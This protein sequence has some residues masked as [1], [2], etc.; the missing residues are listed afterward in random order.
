[1]YK[2]KPDTALQAVSGK[3]LMVY[4]G[5]SVLIRHA[6]I[7]VLLYAGR[8]F[9]SFHKSLQLL[10]VGKPVSSLPKEDLDAAD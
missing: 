8:D 2:K 5:G 10:P 6:E 1:M 4:G 9:A 3:D 7:T